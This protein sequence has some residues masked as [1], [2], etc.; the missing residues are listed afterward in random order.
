MGNC[1]SHPY[2][3]RIDRRAHARQRVDEIFVSGGVDMIGTKL[4]ARP[5]KHVPGFQC[6]QE[7]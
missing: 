2:W 1:S 5:D 6:D 4:A 7:P 3:N